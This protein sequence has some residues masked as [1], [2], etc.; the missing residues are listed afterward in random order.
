MYIYEW[1]RSREGHLKWAGKW[2]ISS[3]VCVAYICVIPCLDSSSVC[4]FAQR[5]LNSARHTEAGPVDLISD[6]DTEDKLKLPGT[7]K[8]MWVVVSQ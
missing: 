4:H 2:Y 5:Y 6:D 7:L 1:V 3:D 8:G